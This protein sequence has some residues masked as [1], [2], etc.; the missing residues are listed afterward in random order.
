MV[1][2]AKHLE[3]M[4]CYSCHATWASSYY[5]YDY[6]ID[7]SNGQKMIDWVASAGKIGKNGT[8]ADFDGKSFIMQKGGSAGDYSHARFEEPILGIN[9]EGR[10]T[11]LV[12]VIQTVGTV[13][14][15]KGKV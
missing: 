7:F 5:G 15:E 3:T 13:I 9:G 4:E 2:A 8:P 10:V 14:D 11:P 1:G 6:S 12:G